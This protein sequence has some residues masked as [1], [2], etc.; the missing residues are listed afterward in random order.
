MPRKTP[1][2]TPKLKSE[3]DAMIAAIRFMS[4]GW[5]RRGDSYIRTGDANGNEWGTIPDDLRALMCVDLLK[6]FSDAAIKTQYGQ[7]ALAV[8]REIQER[9]QVET[10]KLYDFFHEIEA[11]EARKQGYEETLDLGLV[12]DEP[13]APA[14]LETLPQVITE[15]IAK[16]TSE[17]GY[18]PIDGSASEFSIDNRQTV[19]I[20]ASFTVPEEMRITKSG[21]PWKMTDT[22]LMIQDAIG[23]MYMA[24]KKDWT[25]NDLSVMM[26]GTRRLTA[27][28]RAELEAE[29]EVQRNADYFLDWTNQLND[30]KKNARK[31][32]ERL[33]D[34]NKYK[35]IFM[36][37]KVLSVKKGTVKLNNGKANG[38]EVVIYHTNAEP[39]IFEYSRYTGQIMNVPVAALNVPGVNSGVEND[40]LMRHLHLMVAIANRYKTPQNILV[41]TI[42][43][44]LYPMNEK[45]NE[46]GEKTNEA[47]EKTNEAGEKK[48]VSRMERA[49]VIGRVTRCLEHYAKIKFIRKFSTIQGARGTVA[50]WTITPA[51][52]TVHALKKGMK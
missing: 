11:A 17:A 49:R 2:I 40:T 42:L 36:D 27:K 5:E 22:G 35:A 52:K 47:G 12:V 7:K 28:R 10:Q 48:V 4:K 37:D 15:S 45:T 38:K 23:S 26:G 46:A 18:I 6:D 16:I 13:E 30:M 20:T 8:L 24:G 50:G 39:G 21:K 19:T 1:K 43:E 14:P 33:K 32:P 3:L 51:K 44:K 29:I 31:D 25:L 41:E 34:L 9:P